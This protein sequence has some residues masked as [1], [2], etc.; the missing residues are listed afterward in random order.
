MI[1][2]ISDTTN[3]LE[4]T[5]I[6][7]SKCNLN[8][9]FCFV[10]GNRK[11]NDTPITEQSIDN[12]FRCAYQLIQSCHKQYTDV[13][14]MGG[15]I[16]LDCYSNSVISRYKYHMDR[17]KQLC[18]DIGSTLSV[19]YMTNLIYKKIDRVINLVS[20]TNGELHCSYD[21]YGRFKSGA[22][23]NLWLKNIDRVKQ[24]QIPYFVSIV[25]TKRNVVVI[26]N[27]SKECDVILDNHP[28]YIGYYER[29]DGKSHDNDYL[30][31]SQYS[32]FLC[33]INDQYPAD[34]FIGDLKQYYNK[35]RKF[36]HRSFTIHNGKY[37]QCCDHDLCEKQYIANHKCLMCRHFTRCPKP[38]PRVFANQQCPFV[39]LFDEYNKVVQ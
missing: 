31:M 28:F 17:I 25:A 33:F 13:V 27:G 32:S 37:S 4:I 14:L 24:S 29:Q 10:V 9:D 1:P 3:R 23:R 5:I 6:L 7:S 39:E 36:C 30:P 22:V 18:N 21:F 15:E 38:C 19:S 35:H 20:E 2:I 16:F 8:C 11:F 12:D 34:K 26:Q